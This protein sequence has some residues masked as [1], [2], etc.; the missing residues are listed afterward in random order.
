VNKEPNK[1][2]STTLGWVFSPT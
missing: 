2:T 1:T